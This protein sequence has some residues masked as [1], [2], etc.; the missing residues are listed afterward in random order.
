MTLAL[1]TF[2]QED[3]PTVGAA[4]LSAA[5]PYPGGPSFLGCFSG[6]WIG[7]ALL[8]LIAR[9]WGRPIA[10]RP[11]ARCFFDP[12]A[13]ARSEQWFE[14]KGSLALVEQPVCSGNASAHLPRGWLPA[15]IVS[16]LSPCD[17]DC[18]RPLDGSSLRPRSTLRG[19]ALGSNEE[20]GFRGVGYA[21]ARPGSW[22]SGSVGHPKSFGM[23]R[24]E[25]LELSLAGGSDGSFGQRGSSTFPSRSITSTWRSVT[26]DSQS[27]RLRILESSRAALWESLKS[28]RSR[29]ERDQPRIHGSGASPAR[30][31]NRRKIRVP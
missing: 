16:A 12:V 21:P 3:T 5:G 23:L 30:L 18:R 15:P 11:W 6:I 26:G 14:K 25:S 10:E 7:D 13:V 1:L 2:V 28:R 19:R 31:D 4:L 24:G 20:L 22:C 17:G 29:L 8:Y 9:S 27:Q